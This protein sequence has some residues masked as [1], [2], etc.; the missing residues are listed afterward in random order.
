[1]LVSSY[2]V[3]IRFSDSLENVYGVSSVTRY[4]P[5]VLRQIA[6]N[7]NGILS[8][9]KALDFLYL[10]TK[11]MLCGLTEPLPH[12]KHKQNCYI[13]VARGPTLQQQSQF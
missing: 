11:R 6:V 10:K 7:I 13:S 8:E 2:S 9:K 12:V 3:M 1:M 5:D 4:K